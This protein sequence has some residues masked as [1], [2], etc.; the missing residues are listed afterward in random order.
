MREKGA[1]P[2]QPG[3]ERV[4]GRGEAGRGEAG[5]V[6]RPWRTGANGGGPGRGWPVGDTAVGREEGLRRAG[7][8]D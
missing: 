6:A 7:K 5:R 2:S 1:M 8:R 3:G 4:A